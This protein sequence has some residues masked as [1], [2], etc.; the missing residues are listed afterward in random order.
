MTN[1]LLLPTQFAKAILSCLISKPDAIKRLIEQNYRLIKLLNNNPELD[2]YFH[3]L[4]ILKKDKLSTLN[5]L[6][7][8]TPIESSLA[9]GLMIFIDHGHSGFFLQLLKAIDY[10][11]LLLLNTKKVHVV[12]AIKLNDQQ[13]KQLEDA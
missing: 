10:H 6:I 9:Y 5:D 7:S 3:D 11:G 13:K 2:A 4:T 1:N 12:S 8:A